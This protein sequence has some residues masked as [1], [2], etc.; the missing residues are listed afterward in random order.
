LGALP[1]KVLTELY[2]HRFIPHW[3]IDEGT[4][5]LRHEDDW[6]VMGSLH[7]VVRLSN[8]V[9]KI[10]GKLVLTK[11]GEK[12]LSP[13]Y[14]EQLFR[15]V[16]DTFTREFNWAYNDFYPNFSMCRNAFT[17]SVYLLA[18]FGEAER[19]KDFYAEKFLTA[20]PTSLMEFEPLPY[21]SPEGN[22]KSCY[23]LRT[24]DRFLE[25]FNLVD[26][27]SDVDSDWKHNRSLVKRNE[28]MDAVFTL[29]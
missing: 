26:V 2:D 20:F 3:P 16:F 5:I 28:I 22:F 18:R 24:F 14:R 13:K 8:L 17:F 12:L 27:R 25:W 1:R 10:H 6:S 9:R 4:L 11:L 19:D 15:L 23:S 21:G 7:A 29:T